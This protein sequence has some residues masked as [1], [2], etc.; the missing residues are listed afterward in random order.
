MSVS[1]FTTIVHAEI[2]KPGTD[3]NGTPNQIGS[4]V[5]GLKF[6]GGYYYIPSVKENPNQVLRFKT[7]S[8]LPC[9]SLVWTTTKYLHGSI[10]PIFVSNKRSNK[11]LYGNYSPYIFIFHSLAIL[12]I[13]FYFFRRGLHTHRYIPRIV[14]PLPLSGRIYPSKTIQE[15]GKTSFRHLMSV[16]TYTSLHDIGMQLLK[17]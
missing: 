9:L 15:F 4:W 12:P 7:N 13:L 8:D 1:D 6:D 14:G 5:G 16:V 11:K 2:S 3:R 10:N 17:T